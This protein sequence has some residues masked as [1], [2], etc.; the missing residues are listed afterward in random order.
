M[1]ETIVVIGAS[2][3]PGRYSHIAVNEL[4]SSGYQ[5]I[6]V[7]NRQGMIGEV[8]VVTVLPAGLK[9]HTATLYIRADLQHLYEPWLS[10]G[11]VGRVIFNPGTE[12]G[13][14][15]QRLQGAGVIALR[16]CTL[17]MLSSGVF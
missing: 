5:V 11:A 1:S 8:P 17:V 16:Q 6:A 3:N 14:L 13:P 10:G 7:G 4:K 12:N 9:A 2:L 15:F